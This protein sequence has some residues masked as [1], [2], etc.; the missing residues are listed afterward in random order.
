MIYKKKEFQVIFLYLVLIIFASIYIAL[1]SPLES[2]WYLF[3]YN[4]KIFVF[5]LSSIFIF[6]ISVLDS[7]FDWLQ[8]IRIGSRKKIVLIQMLQSYYI[9][10]IFINILFLCIIL[11]A[12]LLF[13]K[14]TFDLRILI[15]RYLCYL[16]SFF[17]MINFSIIL[18]RSRIIILKKNPY[19][20]VFLLLITEVLIIIPQ[21]KKTL[22]FDL[23]LLFSWVFYDSII[24]VLLLFLISILLSGY[25]IAICS[26][27]DIL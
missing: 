10:I 2:N 3:W 22:N 8:Y 18:K 23:N 6:E 24:S 20:L 13:P 26:G 19:F 21:I 25:S 16:F 11:G 7:E 12:F 5:L 17:I 14:P 9:A 4:D 1:Q 27:K 15:F